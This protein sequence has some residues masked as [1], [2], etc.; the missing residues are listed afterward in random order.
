MVSSEASPWAKSGGLADVVGALP[1]ALA[2]EGHS[3]ATVIPRYMDAR[4]APARRVIPSLRIALGDGIFDTAIWAMENANPITYFVEQPFLFDRPGLYGDQRGDFNDNHIRF[5][6]LSK[7][8]LEISRRLFAA[9]IIHCHDWQAS[10]IP[11]WL[12]NPTAIDPHFVGI[13]TLL[14]IHN[15]GYQG[16]FDAGAMPDIGLP[17][18][19]Y[20]PAGIEFFG[21]VNFLKAGI[22]F[23]DA[24]TT[25]S[26]KYAEEIQTPEY[27]F[28]LDGLLR[29]RRNVLTG[30]LNGADYDRWNP[31]TDEYIPAH[32]SARDLAGKQICKAALLDEMALPPKAIER[33]LI[34]IIS[35][36]TSQKGFDLIAEAARE[37][38][39]D[40]IYLAALGNG[41][42]M[43]EDLF[44]TLQEEF[45]GRISV[46][47]GY[48]EPLAHRIEAGADMFLMPSRYEPCGLNQMYSLRYGT[49]PVVRATGGLDDSISDA[50]GGAAT[51]FKFHDYNGKALLTAVRR[52]CAAWDDRKNWRAMMVRGMLK[53]FSWNASAGQYSRLYRRLASTGARGDSN[54]LS[55]D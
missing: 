21:K 35:R 11:A 38:F 30:I 19:L 54:I 36:F 28:G 12:K 55:E 48:D 2:R 20:S 18:S 39:R 34:G 6:V 14:T 33:P 17:A 3:V 1:A 5:A 42:P 52:A 32:Y 31:V 9:D 53:D 22:I 25:V 47:L 46:K 15:L 27:G 50:S 7:A 16:L 4:N 45:P 40:D 10:L 51:G 8:A 44:R 41:E 13:R 26:R 29:E 43:W 49:V 37:L 24:L 23:S